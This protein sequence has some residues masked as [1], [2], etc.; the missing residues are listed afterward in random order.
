MYSINMLDNN[1]IGRLKR[2]WSRDFLNRQNSAIYKKI[3]KI[4][5][6]SCYCN[7]RK[8]LINFK[9]YILYTLMR[10]MR[11]S[12]SRHSRPIFCI[13]SNKFFTENN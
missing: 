3:I 1:I 6:F 12:T 11:N 4:K 7:V 10:Q 8:I 13:I 5:K 9:K 2:N